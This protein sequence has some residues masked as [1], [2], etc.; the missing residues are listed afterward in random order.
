MTFGKREKRLPGI[1]LA[2]IPL[3]L[4][5]VVSIAWIVTV[6]VRTPPPRLPDTSGWNSGDIFFSV[7]NSWESVAVRSIS[8]VKGAAVTDSTPS[9]CGFV[10]RDSTSVQLVHASTSAGRIVAETPEE[11]FRNN[12]SYCLYALPAPAV[13]NTLRLRA[14]IDSMLRCGIPF[15]FNFDHTDASALYCTEFVIEMLELNGIYS[16][17]GLRSHSYIYP[18]DIA[19]KCFRE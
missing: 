1:R 11:Y 5:L 15:D 10:L 7:G 8:S 6:A 19:K 3:I 13:I 4:L 2:V 9:H 16:L 18:E 14:D 17:S 12:G